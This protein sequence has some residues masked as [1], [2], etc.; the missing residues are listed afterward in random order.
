MPWALIVLVTAAEAVGSA[1]RASA[2]AAS[3][4]TTAVEIALASTPPEAAGSV[5]ED[6]EELLGRRGLSARY[7]TVAAIDRDEV[8]RPAAQAP[9]SL[10]C[11]WIDLGVARP[12]R[13]LVYIS[14]TASEQVV[15]RALQLP[16][17][18][19]EV[20]R[21]EVS[22]I[23]A[24]SVEALQAGRPLPVAP[25]PE[26]VSVAKTEP[27]PPAP[28]VPAPEAGVWAS[29]GLGAGMAHDGSATV[30][31]PSF[32]VSALFGREGRAW[33][34]A[35]WVQGGGFAT[36][37]AGD[38]VALRFRGGDLAI[39]GAIGTGPGGRVAARLGLGPGVEVRQATPSLAAG[40][41]GAPGTVAL[42]QSRV[43][44][45]VF[46]RAA[47]RFEIP[48]FGRVGLFALV[49]ADA[50][51]VNPRY[52]IDRQG[53]TEVLYAPDRFRPSFLVGLDAL[54]AGGAP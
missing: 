25:E 1:P 21:E 9:C 30:A 52:M 11:I 26:A 15:I 53:T 37:M 27:E 28:P 29:A 41:G 49:A 5:R 47:A 6:L 19:D 4:A 7:R 42:D 39:L 36:D 50:R 3:Q 22:H 24:T 18:V 40:G 33:S 38:S 13:A 10:A 20:A 32:A 54:L 8:L 2:P 12:G 17:G 35:L 51:V 43:D 31:L 14:A 16:R 23:V 45:A 34:P 48:L 46:V 44:P